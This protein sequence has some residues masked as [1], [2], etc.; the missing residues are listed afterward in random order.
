MKITPRHIQVG[1]QITI[2]GTIKLRRD[3][4]VG[5]AFDGVAGSSYITLRCCDLYKAEITRPERPLEVGDTIGLNGWD[6]E[7]RVVS[8][9]DDGPWVVPSHR[10]SAVPVKVPR[11]GVRR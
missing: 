5:V 9:D 11:R 7:F 6:E 3:D 8:L 10:P 4:F 2:S 1:D